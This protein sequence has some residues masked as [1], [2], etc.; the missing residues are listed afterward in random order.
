M[1]RLDISIT[2]IQK[3][4]NFVKL[5]PLKAELLL[6]KSS[7]SGAHLGGSA[8]KVSVRDLLRKN[9][10]HRAGESWIE[11]LKSSAVALSFAWFCLFFNDNFLLFILASVPANHKT[12]TESDVLNKIAGVLKYDHGKIGAGVVERWQQ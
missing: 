11:K 4:P 6:R 8:R 5:R 1:N 10:Y 3:I 2:I 12:A 7:F 9:G